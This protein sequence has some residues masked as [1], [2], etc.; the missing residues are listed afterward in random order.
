MVVKG[1]KHS[2]D[3]K[4][5]DWKSERKKKNIDADGRCLPIVGGNLKE[6]LHEIK[7]RKDINVANKWSE[8]ISATI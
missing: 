5:H 7:N 3:K 6:Q 2:R 1:F 8:N 4:N